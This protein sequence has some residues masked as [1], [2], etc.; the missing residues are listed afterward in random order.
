MKSAHTWEKITYSHILNSLH[1]FL[2]RTLKMST[3]MNS[4]GLW[5]LPEHYS[6]DLTYHPNLRPIWILN[7]KITLFQRKCLR[8]PLLAA[9]QL[10]KV[11]SDVNLYK[12]GTLPHLKNKCRT[13]QHISTATSMDPTNT[14]ARRCVTM[15]C[16][17]IAMNSL[18]ETTLMKPSN[19][20]FPA[21]THK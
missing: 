8:I 14:Q 16:A 20:C 18:I 9:S 4:K 17:F 10:C 5:T 3:L 1:Y 19:H 15:N 7:S 11:I 6:E 13:C 21:Q 2:K 12:P